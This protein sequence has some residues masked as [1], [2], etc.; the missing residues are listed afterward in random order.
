M[1]VAEIVSELE[2]KNQ[3]LSSDYK[4]MEQR[5]KK[6]VDEKQRVQKDLQLQIEKILGQ[7]S[8]N[9]AEMNQLITVLQED[10]RTYEARFE[11]RLK[12][13]HS[14]ITNLV[15]KLNAKE[16]VAEKTKKEI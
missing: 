6:Y 15:N 1:F 13:Q 11:T 12:D 10:K 8:E 3:V 4:L 5:A 9:E 7:K 14:T 2:A 16:L